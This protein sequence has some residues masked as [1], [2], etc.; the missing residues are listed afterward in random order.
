[1]N[2]L[3]LIPYNIIYVSAKIWNFEQIG[4]VPND[5]S[6]ATALHN[7]NLFNDAVNALQPGD[8]LLIPAGRNFN[9]MESQFF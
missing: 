6:Y 7:G 4:G 9:K 5:D 2:W 8:T 3:I 1:M